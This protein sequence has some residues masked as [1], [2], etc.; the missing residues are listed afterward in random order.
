MIKELYIQNYALIAQ[1]RIN[2]E[3]GFTTI[4]GESGAGKTLMLG[5]L[6]LISGARADFDVIRKGEEKTIVEATF[7]QQLEEVSKILIHNSLDT[8]D[9][10]LLRR[11]L[12]RS[13]RSRAFINDSPVSLNV[14]KEVAELLFQIHGQ[15]ENQVIGK[16]QFQFEQLDSYCKQFGRLREFKGLYRKCQAH[17]RELESLLEA[18]KQVKRDQDYFEFQFNELSSLGLENMDATSL[19]NEYNMLDHAEEIKQTLI[20]VKAG[21]FAD[22]GSLSQLDQVNRLLSNIRTYTTDIVNVADR[23]ESVYIELSD[24]EQDIERVADSVDINPER[25][26]ILESQIDEL[27]KQ[28]SKHGVTSLD[29]LKQVLADYELKLSSIDSFAEELERLKTLT[30]VTKE[31]AI[32]IAKELAQ[33]RRRVV[34]E[35]VNSVNDLLRELGMEKAQIKVELTE[36]NLNLYGLDEIQVLFN[37]ND[38]E[39]LKPISDVASGG[40]VSRLML[41]IKAIESK[42][43]TSLPMVF[44]EIDTGVSGEVAKRMGKLMKQLSANSQIIAVTHSPGVA[45]HG[46]RHINIYKEEHD[47][48]LVSKF[49]T[50]DEEDRVVELATM[51]SGNQITEAALESARLLRKS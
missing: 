49:K 23:L 47:G 11:E 4:T 13:G 35:Y 17:E 16:S 18:S 24:I 8:F 43:K 33:N 40:E 32:E 50:L 9:T 48:Q 30:S 2:F 14:M 38:S 10:V 26:S 44:D 6:N 37:A 12:T 7:S 29:E 34:T 42:N 19:E 21:L 5:A 3:G 28:Y 25:K 20:N 15:H 51:F 36:S 46:D 31:E 45:A 22:S 1:T 41:A 27:N 39:N